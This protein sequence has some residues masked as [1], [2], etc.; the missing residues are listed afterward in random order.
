MLQS[1]GLNKFFYEVKKNELASNTDD[2]AKVRKYK[3]WGFLTPPN[4]SPNALLAP[5][6]TRWNIQGSVGLLSQGELE[7]L[8]FLPGDEVTT[9]WGSVCEMPPAQ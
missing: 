8:D 7:P 3:S 5:T 2:V 6:T 9:L 4:P 1:P